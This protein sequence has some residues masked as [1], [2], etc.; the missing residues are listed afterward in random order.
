MAL[1]F[2]G[3]MN[4]PNYTALS[5]DVTS[6]N[7][8]DHAVIVGA[9]ILLTDTA[10][11][12]IIKSDLTLEDYALPISFNGSVDIGAVHLDQNL[13]DSVELS[14]VSGAK[15]V[16][17]AGTA[18]PLALTNIYFI[19]MLVQPRIGNIG[20]V[21]LGDSGVDRTTSQQIIIIPS[22]AGVVIDAPVGYKH[23]L[24]KW[25]IDAANSNDGVRYTYL[26]E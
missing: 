6:G 19:S 15:A 1:T 9:T 12:K 8:I 25:Y 7:T 23:N 5:T 24:A 26:T 11:W 3:K 2:I 16:T 21:Y 10:V 14:P 22:G 17:V 20:N 18:E 4:V 13:S